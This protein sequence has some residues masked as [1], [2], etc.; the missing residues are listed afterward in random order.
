LTGEYRIESV[1]FL[2]YSG[3]FDGLVIRWFT[4]AADAF[5]PN[6]ISVARRV[7]STITDKLLPNDQIKAG[8]KA[9]IGTALVVLSIG[10][11]K[12][13]GVE[14]LS[15]GGNSSSVHVPISA[16]AQILPNHQ[17]VSTVGS[18]LWLV[19]QAWPA[20]DADASGVERFSV[21]TDAGTPDVGNFLVQVALAPS[22][23]PALRLRRPGKTRPGLRPCAW[24]SR[25]HFDDS[26]DLRL[27][28]YQSRHCQQKRQAQTT[29]SHQP[30]T[31]VLHA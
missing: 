19:F 11:D 1:G 14:H 28:I 3:N 10:Y 20:G 23:Q 6:Y 26:L 7:G 30:H 2:F 9:D 21:G 13:I 31:T 24:A 5:A 15:L 27:A 8:G 22:H 18:N 29:C 17:K 12:S 16:V 4:V 25:R